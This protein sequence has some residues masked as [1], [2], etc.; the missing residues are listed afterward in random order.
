MKYQKISI[1][2]KS[3]SKKSN[4]TSLICWSIAFMVTITSM[5]LFLIN[6]NEMLSLESQYDKYGKYTFSFPSSDEDYLNVVADD[7]IRDFLPVVEETVEDEY[8]LNKYSSDYRIL[9]FINAKIIEGQFPQK[10]NEVAVEGSFL[11]RCGI[12]ENDALGKKITINQHEYIVSGIIYANNE[13]FEVAD[14]NEYTIL[15]QNFDN[16]HNIILTQLWDVSH[17]KQNIDYLVKKYSLN[18]QLC[19]IN[20]DLFASIGFVTG[21]D[22]FKSDKEIYIVIYFIILLAVLYAT[23]NYV[24]VWLDGI[25]DVIKDMNILGIPYSLIRMG[26]YV[27][28][29]KILFISIMLGILIAVIGSLLVWKIYFSNIEYLYLITTY[30]YLLLVAGICVFIISFFIRLILLTHRTNII[31]SSKK[32]KCKH[33]LDFKTTHYRFNLFRDNVKKNRLNILISVLSMTLSIVGLVCFCYYLDISNHEYSYDTTMDYNVIFS[34]DYLL[35]ENEIKDQMNTYKVLQENQGDVYRIWPFFVECVEQ[36]IEKAY[37]SDEYIEII[38]KTKKD[39][40]LTELNIN[41]KVKTYISVIGYNEEQLREL[42]ELNELDYKEMKNN[43]IIVLENTGPM[44]NGIKFSLNF[45]KGDVISLDNQDYE[46]INTVKELPV[47]YGE[48]SNQICVIVNQTYMEQKNSFVVPQNIY[49]DILDDKKV[50]KVESMLLSKHHCEIINVDEQR[51]V[52][53]SSNRT[54]YAL[55]LLFVIIVICVGNSIVSNLYK[56]Y[57]TN[58]KSY[59]IMHLLGIS[60]KDIIIIWLYEIV[61]IVIVSVIC[62]TP[63]IAAITYYIGILSLGE[64]AKYIYSFPIK[65][66]VLSIAIVC[67]MSF[68]AIWMVSKYIIRNLTIE[69]IYSKQ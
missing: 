65:Y 38:N 28:F 32:R 47:W 36:E 61:E 20:F 9:D 29:I 16:N 49:I 15:K 33:I 17:Y 2:K 56:R 55:N 30:P 1:I 53:K 10:K 60:D 13:G 7:M 42:Y 31:F 21:D 63:I 44:G 64:L 22:S 48:F 8:I 34:P 45:S 25:K 19:Y 43:Q 11:Y 26:I 50:D 52:M 24:N 57:K 54:R 59:K 3:L 35:D 62:V 6:G 5:L 69:N 39:N 40:L 37:L 14:D 67:V 46:I 68:I 51:K 12:G 23:I 18:K 66:Y 41:N 27:L 4:S 58:C